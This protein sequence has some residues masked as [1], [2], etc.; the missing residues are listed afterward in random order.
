MSA[1]LKFVYPT[2]LIECFTT[3]C[4]FATV[5][6]ELKVCGPNLP[7][8]DLMRRQRKSPNSLTFFIKKQTGYSLCKT[9]YIRG[10]RKR[11]DRSPLAWSSGKSVRL[12]ATGWHWQSSSNLTP[13]SAMLF[14]RK[15]TFFLVSYSFVMVM[16]LFYISDHTIT[17]EKIFKPIS[18]LDFI[19]VY[20]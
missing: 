11:V 13:Q 18:L 16:H 7:I 15:T 3:Y 17:L 20:M 1:I 8:L 19:G 9:Y 4:S 10:P 14:L 5:Y 2:I 6:T 12:E